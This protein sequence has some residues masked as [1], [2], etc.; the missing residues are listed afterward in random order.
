MQSKQLGGTTIHYENENLDPNEEPESGK[1]TIS[2]GMKILFYILSFFI[3]V[4]GLII[5]AIYYSIP[6]MKKVGKTCVILGVLSLLM[7]TCLL[8]TMVLMIG[9]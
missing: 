4:F 3:P 6:E 5:G 2:D 8:F 1:E 9:M 7:S